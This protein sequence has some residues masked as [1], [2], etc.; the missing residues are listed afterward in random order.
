LKYFSYE[1]RKAVW[2]RRLALLFFALF[3]ATFGLHHLDKLPTPTAM[4]LFGVSIAGAIMAALLGFAALGS[5]WRE[6]FTGA[7]KAI[8]GIFLA[9]I[10][11]AGPIWMMPNILALPRMYEVSTDLQNPPEFETIATIRSAERVNPIRFTEQTAKLQREAYPDVEPL[12]I[13]RPAEDTYGAVRDAVKNLGWD[14]V[15]E[16]PP[17]NGEAARIEATDRSMIFGF[18]DDMVIRVAGIGNDSRVDVRSS[19]RHGDHDL[20][21]NAERVRVL[22]SEVKTRLAEIDKNEAMKRAL[23]LREMQMQKVLEAKERQRIAKE[24]EE[25]ERRQ[26]NAALRRESQIS[27]SERDDGGGSRTTRAQSR[28]EASRERAR[29]TRQRRARRTRALRRFWEGLNQ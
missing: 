2:S 15:A 7:G 28:Q 23:A 20:G 25:R 8:G 6:G 10:I 3:V 18:R 12:P 27:S 4:K 26:Q 14:I 16:K 22:F 29:S 24:R 1:S 17:E 13:D 21:R 5:I 19:A 9:A 11:L